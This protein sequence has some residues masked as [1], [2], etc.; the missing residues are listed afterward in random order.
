M[1]TYRYLYIYI[2]IHMFVCLY[3]CMHP[4]M[5]V[6][7]HAHVYIRCMHVCICVCTYT[8]TYLHM[9]TYKCVYTCIHERLPTNKHKSTIRGILL[10]R[11]SVYETI[12]LVN[13]GPYSRRRALS[14]ILKKGLPAWC[15]SSTPLGESSRVMKRERSCGCFEDY[16]QLPTPMFLVSPL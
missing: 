10:G 1:Y 11:V 9:C 3:V 16:L 8:Y 13:I 12:I 5:H 14:R 7:M 6:Y 2:S 4:C 15:S